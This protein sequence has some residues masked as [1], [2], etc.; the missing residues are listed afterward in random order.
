M[1]DRRAVDRD[2]LHGALLWGLPVGLV[3][4]NGSGPFYSPRR[5]TQSYAVRRRFARSL[6]R[7]V[8]RDDFSVNRP[9]TNLC[10]TLAISVW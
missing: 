5:V 2:E 10:N 4:K 1:W 3:R 9:V 7:V 8:R 6:E